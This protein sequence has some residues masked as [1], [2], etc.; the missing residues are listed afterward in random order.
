MGLTRGG[1]GVTIVM[2]TWEKCRRRGKEDSTSASVFIV[3][4][5]KDLCEA[6]LTESQNTTNWVCSGGG[7]KEIMQLAWQRRDKKRVRAAWRKKSL[8]IIEYPRPAHSGYRGGC[9]R[10]VRVIA[11]LRSD[12]RGDE[13]FSSILK[14]I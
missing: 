6:V 11:T 14:E 13:M 2:V 12:R 4:F 9:L 7:T 1:A 8:W 3:D 10:G 5:G